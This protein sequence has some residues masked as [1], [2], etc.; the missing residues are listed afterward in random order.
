M[1]QHEADRKEGSIKVIV[2]Y[3][4]SVCSENEII[5]VMPSYEFCVLSIRTVLEV[6]A[7][8]NVFFYE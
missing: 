4:A 3:K 6:T 1:Y 7:L 2:Y 5:L 8:S